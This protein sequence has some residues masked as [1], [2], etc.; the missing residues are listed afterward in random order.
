V[1]REAADL[2]ALYRKHAAGAFRRA[3]CILR[4]DADAH[5]VVHDLYLSLLERPEQF[6]GHNELTG[7][8]YKAV[9]HACLNRLRNQRTRTRLLMERE[10]P[11]R[12]SPNHALGLEQSAA[13]WSELERMPE[14]L[15]AVAI[16]Y[17]VDGMT[18]D[19]IA[20]LLECSPRHVGNL[21]ARLQGWSLRECNA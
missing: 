20:L 7:F 17:Y 14:T 10:A 1:K 12:L 2:E 6:V 18:H 13:L 3:R 21:V 11:Q 15:A 8:I 4:S 5:E 16:Y 9:T 19:E